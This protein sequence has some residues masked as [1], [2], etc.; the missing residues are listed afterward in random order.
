MSFLSCATSSLK[1]TM[2][3]SYC[4]DRAAETTDR[5]DKVVQEGTDIGSLLAQFESQLDSIK[6]TFRRLQAYE[7]GAMVSKDPRASEAAAMAR[8]KQSSLIQKE[9]LIKER[10]EAAEVRKRQLQD[11]ERAL[12]KQQSFDELMLKFS[13]KAMNMFKKM[14]DNA[15]DRFF[16]GGR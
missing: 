14:A 2:K 10:Q 9:G 16:G 8:Q 7:D 1:Y 5:L 6:Y 12:T 11:Q 13:T 3:S 15:L 4:E